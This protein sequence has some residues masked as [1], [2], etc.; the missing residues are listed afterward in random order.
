MTFEFTVPR[1]VDPDG[2]DGSPYPRKMDVS[3]EEER[4]LAVSQT[5]GSPLRSSP[6]PVILILTMKVSTCY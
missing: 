6:V 3:S 5:E 2:V 4:Q 1:I